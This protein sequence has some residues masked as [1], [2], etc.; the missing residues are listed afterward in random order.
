MREREVTT[1]QKKSIRDF[2]H[3]NKGSCIDSNSRRIVDVLSLIQPGSIGKH[4][5]RVWEVVSV[6]EQYGLFMNSQTIE[7]YKQLYRNKYKTPLQSMFYQ[8]RCPCVKVTS[9]QS[10]VDILESGCL[11]YIQAL[12]KYIQQKPAIKSRLTSYSCPQH[13]LPRYQQ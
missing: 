6:D 11:H 3:A 7:Q 13:L 2:C 5:G 1:L 12:A 8:N 9:V 4:V 10:C